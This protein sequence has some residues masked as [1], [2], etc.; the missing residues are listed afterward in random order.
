MTFIKNLETHNSPISHNKHNVDQM[1]K[2]IN[3]HAK[4]LR[5][6]HV[7][8]KASPTKCILFLMR[9]Y[10]TSNVHFSHTDKEKKKQNKPQ[11]T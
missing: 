8:M 6:I 10:N 7:S 1:Q 11:H 3:L 5:H 2:K 4:M 9:L